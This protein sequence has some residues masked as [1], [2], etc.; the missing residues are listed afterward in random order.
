MPSAL[1]TFALLWDSGLCFFLDPWTSPRRRLDWDC[2]NADGTPLPLGYGAQDFH[3]PQRLFHERSDGT[4]VMLVFGYSR[5]GVGISGPEPVSQVDVFLRLWLATF[6]A[7]VCFR[8]FLDSV[9][10]PALYCPSP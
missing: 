4:S 1:R 2:Q 10:P 9:L 5:G 7:R 8:M 3:C 6:A